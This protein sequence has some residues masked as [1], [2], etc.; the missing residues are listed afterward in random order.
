MLTHYLYLFILYQYVL[1]IML[2]NIHIKTQLKLVVKYK[3]KYN[4][5]FLLNF[6]GYQWMLVYTTDIGS[7]SSSSE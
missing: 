7:K 1:L 3:E 2:D 5:V 4:F 6:L